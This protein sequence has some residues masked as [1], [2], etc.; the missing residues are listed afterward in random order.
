[1]NLEPY[2]A[3]LSDDPLREAYTKRSPVVPW[4]AYKPVPE[5]DVTTVWEKLC[6][7]P[8]TGKTVAYVHVPFCRNHCLFCDF[9]RNATRKGIPQAYVEGVVKEIERE[10]ELPMVS[11]G[12]VHAVYLGGGTPTDLSA[13]ELARLIETLRRC[14]PLAADCEITVEG[15]ATGCSP[16]KIAACL[17]AGANRFSFGVQSFDSQVRKSLGRKMDAEEL[18]DFLGSVCAH[19]RAAVVCDL[20]FGLPNQTEESWLRDIE[21]VT[22]LGLDGVDLY[23]LTMLP[24]SPLAAAVRNGAMPAGAGVGGQGA[25]YAAGV[26]A[27]E[28][29]GWRQLTNAHFA[30]ETRERNLYNQLIKSGASCLAYGAGAGGAVGGYSFSV[31]TDLLRYHEAIAEEKKP[32]GGL[33]DA[34]KSRAAKAAVTGGVEVGRLNLTAVDEAGVPGFA[35]TVRPLARQ[36]ERAGLVVCQDD[37]LRLTVAGRFWHTNLTS[38]LHRIA[39]AFVSSDTNLM[40]TSVTSEPE[41]QTQLA[42]LRTRFA[43]SA[44][45]VLETIALES[46]LTTREVVGCLP[47]SCCQVVE[48]GRFTE[49]MSDIS[50]WGEILL[51]VHTADAVIECAGPLP[52][53][54]FGRGFF[55]LGSGSP[56]RGHIRADHCADICLVRR[57]FMGMDTCSVQFFNARGETMFKIFVSRDDDDELN[58]EQV[59]RFEGLRERFSGAMAAVS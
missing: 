18:Q 25:L 12:P 48:G 52:K 54:K 42:A 57:S 56:I 50:E 35:D 13:Q 46:G 3:R 41:K 6:Q 7:L 32:L 8:R 33:Y 47:E 38:A 40:K 58:A 24:A 39:D 30:R 9:Y 11:S 1:M 14:L 19:D 27:L 55:N 45:G 5:N 20:I 22:R 53:G 59:S 2:F 29:E 36:W 37:T 26:A 34:G 10:A 44:D 4:L 15:R 17:D 28:N 23:A 49:V 31:A 16:D 43:K 21:I 51:L